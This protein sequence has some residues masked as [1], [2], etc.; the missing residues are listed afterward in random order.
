MEALQVLS[1]SE[2]KNIKGGA[3][4][5]LV[6]TTPNGTESWNRSDGGDADAEC[7]AIYP[8]YGSEVTGYWATC[9]PAST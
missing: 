5:C 6:C 2:M 1:R 8:A 4:L 9:A 3:G 7:Q